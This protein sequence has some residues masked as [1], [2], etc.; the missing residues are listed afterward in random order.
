[1]NKQKVGRF[2]TTVRLNKKQICFLEKLAKSAKF[3]GGKN[4]SK[5]ALLRSLISMAKGLRLD[6]S[7]VKTEE[8]LKERFLEAFSR[9]E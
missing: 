6:V 8:E 5:T 9:Y 1:M 2:W 4:F 7:G 3:T